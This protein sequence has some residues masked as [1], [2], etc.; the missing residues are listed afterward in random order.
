MSATPMLTPSGHDIVQFASAVKDRLGLLFPGRQQDWLRDIFEQRLRV[1]GLDAVAYFSQLDAGALPEETRVL[2]GALTV[3]ETFFFRHK[4]QFDA[5]RNHVLPRL[6]AANQATRSL[7]ILSVGCASGEE[8]Y[9]IAMALEALGG[10]PGWDV[11]IVGVDVN[12][13]AIEKARAASY[14]AWSLRETGA[15]ERQRWFRMSGSSYFL[16][17]SIR[18]RVQFHELNLTQPAPEFWRSQRF[19]LVFCRNVLMY[20]DPAVAR[21]AVARIH[22]ATVPGA[23]LFLGHAEHLRDLSRDFQLCQSHSCFYYRH[24]DA[25][26][27]IDVARVR[28]VDRVEVPTGSGA[29]AE[30]A[31]DMDWFEAI[32]GATQR[33]RTLGQRLRTKAGFSNTASD[34]TE[35]GSA[36]AK[37]MAYF[38]HDQFEQALRLLGDV[39]PSWYRDPEIQLLRIVLLAHQGELKQAECAASTLVLPRPWMAEA[40]HALGLCFENSGD[41]AS[42]QTRYKMAAQLDPLFAMPRMHLGLMARRQG[43]GLDGKREL[44]DALLL[45]DTEQVRRI[46]LFGGGFDRRALHDVCRA[47]LRALRAGP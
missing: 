40:H 20:L 32:C 2:A 44:E 1:K 30:A 22:Q 8:P 12:P 27:A 36:I 38:R 46:Q 5:L 24:G 3:G 9:S 13:K 29:A 37:A 19:D 25:G 33:V 18:E 41:H 31:A 21:Q 16:A 11:T 10:L 42:A 6:I 45:L 14:G 17:P 4:E 34:P 15:D 35:R 47:E 39:D 7:R 23:Y 26:E 28:D 43:R